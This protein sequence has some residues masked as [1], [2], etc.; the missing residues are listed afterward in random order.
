MQFRDCTSKI[1]AIGQV[2]TVPKFNK[3]VEAS[4]LESNI[5]YIC[6]VCLRLAVSLSVCISNLIAGIEQPKG[7]SFE[8]RIR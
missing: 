2:S 1:G 5:W 6:R 7:E 4:P 8:V 3:K